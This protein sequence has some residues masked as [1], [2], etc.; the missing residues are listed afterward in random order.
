MKEKNEV[1][2]WV[3]LYIMILVFAWFVYAAIGFGI[4][5][6]DIYSHRHGIS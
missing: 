4:T 6:I 3:W 2:E 5:L 1:V